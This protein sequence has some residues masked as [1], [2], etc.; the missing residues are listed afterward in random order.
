MY[1]LQQPGSEAQRIRKQMLACDNK[2]GHTAGV[3]LLRMPAGVPERDLG[4][5]TQIPLLEA[6]HL[7]A[8]GLESLLVLSMLAAIA[9]HFL[10]CTT[11][12]STGAWSAEAA[13][14]IRS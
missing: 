2:D 1:S 4:I 5:G 14:T 7:A 6:V 12:T 13:A 10:R 11:D 3:S 8:K 9:S